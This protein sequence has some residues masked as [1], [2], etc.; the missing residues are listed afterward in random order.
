MRIKHKRLLSVL[1]TLCMV[2]AMVPAMTLPAFAAEDEI[3]HIEVTVGGVAKTL[4]ETNSFLVSG[5]PASGGTLDGTTCTAHF[6]KTEQTLTLYNYD[7]G[8]I[9]I[10]G[11]SLADFTIILKENNKITMEDGVDSAWGIRGYNAGV[12]LVITTESAGT[13]SLDIA[14]KV[15]GENATAYGIL[16]CQNTSSLRGT[17]KFSGNAAVNVTAETTDGNSPT[18]AVFAA[19]RIDVLENASLIAT[20]KAV[21]RNVRAVSISGTTAPTLT[22]NTTEDVTLKASTE[23]EN[24]SSTFALFARRDGVTG[25]LEVL[26]TKKLSMYSSGT[27][28]RTDATP[29][30]SFN[31]TK[32]TEDQGVTEGGNHLIY[33]P[34][35]GGGEPDTVIT[36]TVTIDGTAQFNEELEATA[37]ITNGGFIGIPKYQWYR[38]DD[39]IPGA[40]EAKYTIV[41]DDIGKTIKVVVTAD[42][43]TGSITS[44]PTVTI[45]KAPQGQPTGT[46]TGVAP[47][48]VGGNDGYIDG[49]NDTME[50]KSGIASPYSYVAVGNGKT[51][52]ENLRRDTYNV[53]YKETDTHA[54]GT[55]K[56]ILV[57]GRWNV[58]FNS[59]GGTTVPSVTA[60]AYEKITEPTPPTK[61]GYTFAGWYQEA[62][63]NNKWIFDSTKIGNKDTTLY[64]KWTAI[65]YTVTVTSGGNGTAGADKATANVGDT[66]TLTATPAEGYKF[67]EWQSDDVTV[68][69]SSTFTMPAKNVAVTAVFEV[70]D[71]TPVTVES[72]SIKTSPTTT[73]Y[74]EGDILDLTGLEVTLRKSDSTTED[75][76]LAQF[77][78][79]GLTASPANE[80]VLTTANDKVTI[81]HTAS[82]KTVD[83]NITVD[84]AA[85]TVT[86]VEVSPSSTSVQKGGT[87]TFSGQVSLS[88]GT[89]NYL[90]TWS[91]TGNNSD[92]TKIDD[93]GKLTVAADETATSLT[94]TATSNQDSSKKGTA[95]VTV[96]EAPV[97]KY[98]L[99]VKNGT[100]GD[101]YA[102]NAEITIVAD[103]APEGK[104]FDKW[105][106]TVDGVLAD[107]NSAST[108]V[109]MPANDVTVTA[110]YKDKSVTP[111]TYT[112]SFAPGDGS[113]T[114]SD[115]T[116]TEGVAFT[117]PESSFTAPSGKVFKAWDI[118]GTEYTP[119]YS[120]TFTS[121]TTVT[122]LWR[123]SSVITYT[124]SISGGGSGA[125]GGGSY[126]ESD[127]VTI[128]AGNRSNYTF[129][130]WTSADVTITNAS[131][132]TASF[133]M[134]GKN[135]SVTANW[136]YSGGGGGGSDSG[137]DST[138]TT[139]P[140]TSTAPDWLE[141]GKASQSTAEAKAGGHSYALTRAN[142]QYGVRAAAWAAFSG[143]QYWHDTMDG[144][145][146]QVRVY[147]NNPTAITTDLLVSGYVTGA[148]AQATTTLF[149]KYFS[150]KVRT[151]HLD[152]TGAWGQTVELAA[153]VDLAG[154]DVTKLMIYSY[155]K[156]TNTYR[157]IENPAYWVDKNGYLHFTT[158]YAGDIVISEGALALIENG[159]AK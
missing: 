87:Q 29:S 128:Y 151:I 38:G 89:V 113:G 132:K 32:F 137:D 41:K 83:V 10:F 110:T 155:D 111:A 101:E 145:A 106:S 124:V 139:P 33:T 4:N 134:P 40:T 95:T 129:N 86:K 6:N 69:E 107:E 19:D 150:N 82:G 48:T 66:I 123:D 2:L 46:I 94:V 80:A 53:R 62:E 36:G 71:V 68:S 39:A 157:R 98:T 47:T 50:Y 118:D 116:A 22:I 65:D 54:P 138:T 96:T 18:Y 135:V 136:T 109:T 149:E 156:A 56:D 79:K 11:D 84:A 49:V 8:T 126:E 9:K 120:Y 78:A 105:T 17:L 57:P 119:G 146:V 35:G 125:T 158:P 30:V 103:T 20:A 42:D 115:E 117:L 127:L 67:K 144:N 131:S 114:M 97:T 75:V 153:R 7:N 104:E 25:K 13:G 121:N 99:T 14:V 60:V 90:V 3:S 34:K 24:I 91:V 37:T 141:Q 16:T 102:E 88:N 73:T 1:L 59:N 152:Q 43:Y 21:G 23:S 12:N 15:S 55:A 74:T 93:V 130:G 64:A 63:L 45:T 81:T 52:I 31:D 72:I 76:A 27:V 159:G 147:V 100:G 142:G 51:K 58:F 70:N 77:G 148:Q 61:D 154:M 85:V 92:D 140:A 133:T 5:E 44:A 143:Y 26:N 122:A 108:T 112:I 28:V